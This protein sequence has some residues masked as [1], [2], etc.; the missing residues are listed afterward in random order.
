MLLVKS[1]RQ[2]I[3][4]FN[5][6]ICYWPAFTWLHHS[7]LVIIIETNNFNY[8]LIEYNTNIRIWFY[9][10]ISVFDD[11]HFVSKEPNKNYVYRIFVDLSTRN[12][13]VFNFV[14]ENSSKQISSACSWNGWSDCENDG[15]ICIINKKSNLN[16]FH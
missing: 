3:I 6:G 4:K 13:M 5:L 9:F 16:F 12:R 15:H 2:I 10:L 14:I 1:Q 8:A 11:F 7:T